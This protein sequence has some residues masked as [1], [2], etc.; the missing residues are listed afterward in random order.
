MNNKCFYCSNDVAE[1]ESHFVIFHTANTEREEIL[2]HECYQEWL[3]EI[4]G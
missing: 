2:C 1:S 4:K 3:E